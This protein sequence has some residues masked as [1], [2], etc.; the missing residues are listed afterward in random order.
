MCS[1]PSPAHRRSLGRTPRWRCGHQ[2]D[3]R[4][5][6]RD[7]SFRERFI[8]EASVGRNIEHPSA[9]KVHEVVIDGDMIGIT[10]LIE[11]YSLQGNIRVAYELEKAL[12]ILKPVASALDHLHSRESSIVTS[13]LKIYA[14]GTT[15][16][17]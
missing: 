11:G 12:S 16:H 9:N 14:S 15:G 6:T 1:L 8:R 17:Q 2:N 7:P 4:L 5:L 3:A 10:D 13:N